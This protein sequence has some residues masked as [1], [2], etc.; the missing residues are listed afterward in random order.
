M[1]PN[2]FF[3]PFA[4][5]GLFFYQFLIVEFKGWNNSIIA[6][7]LNSYAISSAFSILT[8]GPLIDKY[9]A[10]TFFPF[11][12]FPYFIALLFIWLVGPSWAIYPYM[13]LMG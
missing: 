9:S 12:L 13:I 5:T 1:A 4:I 6:V 11:Y 3:I 10:R 2:V 7:G 8:A